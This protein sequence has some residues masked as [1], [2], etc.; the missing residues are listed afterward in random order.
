MHGIT[1]VGTVPIQSIRWSHVT[2]GPKSTKFWR[3]TSHRGQRRNFQVSLKIGFFFS[4]RNQFFSSW[5][6]LSN[7]RTSSDSRCFKFLTYR[8]GHFDEIFGQSH[9]PR[10]CDETKISSNDANT[11]SD[12]EGHNIMPTNNI[13]LLCRV[14]VTSWNEGLATMK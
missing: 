9:P 13:V 4:P 3:V 14:W 2:G 6:L 1:V 8:H 12:T 7:L 11:D 5:H 10:S